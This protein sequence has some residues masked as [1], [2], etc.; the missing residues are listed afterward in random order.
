M[1]LDLPYWVEDD[2]FD[3]KHHI[4]RIAVPSPGDDNALAELAT[5]LYNKHLDRSRALWEIWFIEGM[6][7]GKY[8]ILLKSHHC[9]MDGEGANHLTGILCDLEPDAEPRPVDES[10]T[11]ARAGSVP[12][13]WQM[14]A[15]TAVHFARLPGEV[16]KGIYNMLRPKFL[17]QLGW[18]KSAPPEKPVVPE[19]SFNG[20]IGNER[21]F[22]FGSLSL[23]DVKAV[24]TAFGVTV[25]D[26]VLALVGSSMRNYLLAHSELP[27]APLRAGIIVSL[28]TEEDDSFS[29]KVISASVNTA[30]DTEDPVA[31][32]SAINKE[33]I[34]AKQQAR[35]GDVGIVEIMQLMPPL[36]IKALIGSTP[37]AM[38]RQMMGAN[39][40]VSTVQS[41]PVPLY[42]AGARL[43]AAYPISIII[44]GI[45]LNFTCVSYVD[46]VDFGVTI[47]PELVPH[48]WDIIS[49]LEAALQEYLALAKKVAGPGKTAAKKK[50]AT[51]KKAHPKKKPPAKSKR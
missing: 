13:L 2:K 28:R 45:G 14:S 41:S 12:H 6:A 43:E 24:K 16:Y 17:R 4:K 30:T 44:E 25:N 23:T 29:N 34:Q 36:V 49:G 19:T 7:N 26:V 5:H 42:I 38:G 31:R 50:R 37:P 27:E 33:S 51:R 8:V 20:V 1:N 21:G 48:P 15:N 9:M 35:S 3:Y 18:D 47:D 22:V 11:S 39:M 32:L 46:N 40:I 10:I